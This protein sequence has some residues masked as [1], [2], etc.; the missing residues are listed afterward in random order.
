[1]SRHLSN[2][3][4][5]LSRTGTDDITFTPKSI[6]AESTSTHIL[7]LYFQIPIIGASGYQCTFDGFSQ[8][9]TAQCVRNSNKLY[10]ERGR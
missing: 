10:S 1:M 9:S 6:N 4:L 2:N 5:I 8:H 7:G 3:K